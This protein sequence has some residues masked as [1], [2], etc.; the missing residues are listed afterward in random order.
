VRVPAQNLLG[1][2]PGRGLQ[3]V[4]AALEKGRINIAA[5]AVGVAQEAYDQ[6][7][8]YA[9]EREAFGQ[10]ISGFQAVQLKLADMAMKLQ[11]ARLLTY[12]AA[13]QA[14]AGHRADL[15]SGLAK[16]YASEVAQECAFTAMQVHGGY[17]YSKEFTVE[18]LYRDA[19]LMVIGEGTNDI[20]RTVIAESLISGRGRV[21]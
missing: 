17:G 20:L 16:V 11:A 15:E 6:A 13:S 19:P 3:Q 9:G 8:R 14:D 2:T 5:R 4:L 18:R 21:G 7:L 10:K 1:G 12:W